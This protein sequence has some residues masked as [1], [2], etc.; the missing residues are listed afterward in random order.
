VPTKFRMCHA[1]GASVGLPGTVV[2]YILV[3]AGATSGLTIDEDT[4]S[5]NADNAFRWDSSGKQWIFNQST[6]KNN[7]TLPKTNTIYR[8]QINL[9]DGSSIQFQHG[10]K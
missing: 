6:G 7:P 3:G 4:Y 2:S 5:T 9:K 1:N 8:F 10:L